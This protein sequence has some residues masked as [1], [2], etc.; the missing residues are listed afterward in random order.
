MACGNLVNGCAEKRWP[1]LVGIVPRSLEGSCQRDV[2]SWL[3][4]VDDFA[5]FSKSA[6]K[7]AELVLV[8]FGVEDA[9]GGNAL[10][11]REHRRVIATRHHDAAM[12]YSL[13]Q[14][15]R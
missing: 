7:S 13:D 10:G 14:C 6:G 5:S 2:E 9:D 1:Q 12:C 3:T 15:R 8:V 11:E 4:L